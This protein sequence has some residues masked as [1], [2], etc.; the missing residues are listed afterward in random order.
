MSW[1]DASRNQV[2]DLT[3]N[4]IFGDPVYSFG[5][6]VLSISSDGGNTWSSAN[7]VSPTPA[8]F[9]GVGRDQFMPG[10]AVDGRGHLAVCYSDRRNDPNNLA[11][12]HFCSIS[13]D[14]GRSF[15]DVR[16]TPTSWSPGHFDD[17]LINP[18]YMGDYDA[19]SVDATGVNAGFFSTF[20]IQT[21]TNPDVFGMRL[22][23]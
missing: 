18:V 4:V 12:D 17:V 9:N 23:Y 21:N 10:V 11:V 20:Q 14:Q 1:T 22:K 13:T 16:E 7:L 19:V 8:E 3:G 2:P 6:I 15:K 5:D